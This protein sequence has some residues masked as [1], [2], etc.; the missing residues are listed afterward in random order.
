M[1]KPLRFEHRDCGFQVSTAWIS[2][3]SSPSPGT[4]VVGRLAIHNTP[5]RVI[6]GNQKSGIHSPVEGT[7]VVYPIVYIWAICSYKSLT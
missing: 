3:Q 7:V 5:I 1:E 6:D 4:P 2:I